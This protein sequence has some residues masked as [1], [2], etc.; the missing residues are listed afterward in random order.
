MSLKRKVSL[1]KE[2]SEAKVSHVGLSGGEPLVHKDFPTL[3]KELYENEISVSIVTNATLLNEE[4]ANILKRYDIYTYVSLDGNKRIHEMLRGEGTFDKVIKGIKILEKYGVEYST[5]MAVSK[6]NYN[7]VKDYLMITLSLKANRAI[8]IPVMPSGRALTSKI[9]IDA[10]DYE[11][12]VKQAK[13]VASKY[14][15]PVSLWCTPFAPIITNSNY[16]FSSFCRGSGSIDID[17][18]GRI[19]ACDIID[20]VVSEV[21]NKRFLEALKDY[22]SSKIIKDIVKPKN[23]PKECLSCPLK[24]YCRGGCY[25]RSLI[26]NGKLNAGDPLC[27]RIGKE[28]E[29]KAKRHA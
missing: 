24:E 14:S 1:I 6:I 23:L 12:A 2:F 28:I 17:S 3:A 27:P 29:V 21:R 19:L 25:S 22:Y 7:Y 5:I 10:N 20:L 16:I 11:F 9:W 15:Y 13:D 8:L 18:Y 4:I 26:V